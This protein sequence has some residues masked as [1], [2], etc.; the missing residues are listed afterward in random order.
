[1][2]GIVVRPTQSL[3][4]IFEMTEQTNQSNRFSST[5][6]YCY[7]FCPLHPIMA[8]CGECRTQSSDVI[9]RYFPLRSKTWWVISKQIRLSRV[10]FKLIS[11]FKAQIHQL[12]PLN[13]F[14]FCP[15]SKSHKV[16]D[17]QNYYDEPLGPKRNCFEKIKIRF[18]YSV[19]W[20]NIITC[21]K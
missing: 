10:G 6:F 11:S 15:K 14:W 1:M 19:R 2:K 21:K 16:P 4:N 13:I 9:S 17:S 7:W 12:T 5:Y 20:N 18:Q 3:T 8:L